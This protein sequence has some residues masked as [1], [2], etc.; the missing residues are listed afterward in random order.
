M[1]KNRASYSVVALGAGVMLALVILVY[2]LRVQIRYDE[3]AHR[4]AQDYAKHAARQVFEPCRTVALA[5]LDECLSRAQT[6]YYIQRNDNRRD[7]ADLV[8]QQRSALWTSIMGVTA[9]VGLTASIIGVW[10]VYATF[11]ETRRTA[12][13]ARRSADAFIANERGKL[14][15]ALS[16]GS[17]DGQLTL[18]IRGK[19]YGKGAVE[20][21]GVKYAMLDSESYPA[22]FSWQE[23]PP[24]WKRIEPEADNGRGNPLCTVR[25]AETESCIIGGWVAYQTQF[26]GEQRAYFLGRLYTTIENE[27]SPVTKYHVQVLERG[28]WPADT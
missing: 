28:G 10:L 15:L 22:D 17:R 18:L 26:P 21:S 13:E 27:Y 19:I 4:E 7:Y 24:I 5:K 25:T 14:R 3:E 8:A 1:I 11:R 20:V 2:G 23:V 16:A 12:D 9:I 6:E